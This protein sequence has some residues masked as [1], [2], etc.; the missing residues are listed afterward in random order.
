VDDRQGQA[1]RTLLPSSARRPAALIAACC[2]VITLVLGVLT[3]HSSRPGWLDASVDSWIRRTFGVHHGTMLLLEDLGKPAEVAVLTLVIAL[4]CLAARRVNGAV[5]AAVSVVVF[6]V[7]TEFVVKPA[8]GRTLG[9]NLVYPSGH[10]GA[11]FTLAAVIVVLLLNPSRRQL[12]R[13]VKIAVAAGVALVGSAVAVA[14]IG[15]HAHYFTD[16]IGG[17]ALAI[18]VVLTTTF[19]LDTERLRRRLRMAGHSDDPAPEVTVTGPDVTTTS[20][21][22]TPAA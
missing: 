12:R 3:A 10:A 20:R 16:T 17:A 2:L 11:A 13:A 9:G 8:V 5:L 14:M 19:L 15:L 7:L 18:G 6:S 21:S 1:A 22:D 4:A